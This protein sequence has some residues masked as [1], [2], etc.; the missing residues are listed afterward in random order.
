MAND[1]VNLRS[2]F[3]VL[4]LLLLA[5]SANALPIVSLSPVDTNVVEGDPFSVD[6][7]I[8]GVEAAHPLNGF[9]FDLD[10]DP[11]VIAAVSV[12]SGGFLLS[13]VFPVQSIVGAT[14]VEFAEV[15]LLAAGASGDGVL[16]TI[17]FIAMGTGISALDLNDVIL[18]EPFGVQ[19]FP[20]RIDDGS[21]TVAAIPEPNAGLVFGIGFS[22]VV[23]RCRTFIVTA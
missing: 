13:P 7:I 5:S 23:W 8:T 12:S 4:S 17:S 9:E 3:A 14:S 19:L 16:A 2:A 6:I 10:F 21:V 1:S 15:T 11:S 22:V 20:D 18:T